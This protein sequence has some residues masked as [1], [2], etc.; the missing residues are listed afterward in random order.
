MEKTLITV[1]V[2]PMYVART[3]YHKQI[4]YG[5]KDGYFP[6]DELSDEP[7]WICDE[8]CIEISRIRDYS[9]GACDE[10]HVWEITPILSI[11][12]TDF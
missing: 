4:R 9:D 11:D 3:F 6:L 10:Y 12:D 8:Y 1:K 7:E 5:F 2:V